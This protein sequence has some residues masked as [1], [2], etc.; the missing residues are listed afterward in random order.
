M[1]QTVIV[2]GAS[3]GVGFG[4]AKVYTARGYRVLGV[5]MHAAHDSLSEIDNYSHCV[6]DLRG[7]QGCEAAISACLDRF[8]RLDVLVEQCRCG[9][10]ALVHGDRRR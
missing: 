3:Q 1:K 5:D 7:R 8:E 10:C 6:T 2:T 9:E 4:I